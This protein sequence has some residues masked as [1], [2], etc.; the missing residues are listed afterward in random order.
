[1]GVALSDGRATHHRRKPCNEAVVLPIFQASR[2]HLPLPPGHLTPRPR[3]DALLS[4]GVAQD[5]GLVLVTAPPGYGKST[6]VSMWLAAQLRASLVAPDPG[7]R[8]TPQPEVLRFAWLSLD[9]GDNDPRRL[10]RHL[11]IALEAVAP[12]A[13]ARL[14][15]RL[16]AGGHEL[17]D[18]LADL[19]AMIAELSAPLVLAIDDA[20]L[21][22]D[23]RA[24]ALLA[25]LVE[26]APPPLRLVLCA[27]A[28]LP[29]PMVTL[30]ASGRLSELGVAELS[31]SADEAADLLG[32][33]MGLS[34]SRG[35]V[36]LLAERSGGWAADL[37]LVGLALQGHPQ[38]AELLA[39]LARESAG[40]PTLA[41]S[42]AA[43][44]GGEGL[45]A[46]HKRASLWHEQAGLLDEAVHY[47]FASGDPHF[48]AALLERQGIALL[49]R[50]EHSALRA[51]CRA[52]PETIYTTRPRLCLI[53]AWSLVLDL[54]GDGRE[55]AERR[56]TQ[57]ERGLAT[58]D[59]AT[60]AWLTGHRAN[61]RGHLLLYAP[62]PDFEALIVY[63]RQA[64]AALPEDDAA[65]RSVSAL[66][67]AYGNM[68]LSDAEGALN[69]LEVA[70]RLALKGR[71]YYGAIS[72]VFDRVR[73]AHQRGRLHEAAELCRLWKEALPSLVQDAGPVFPAGGCLDL[74]LGCVLL[75]RDD[76]AGA[77]ACLGRGLELTGGS[78][79]FAVAGFPA[80]AR[81]C[82]ARGDREGAEAALSRLQQVWPAT[83]FYVEGLLALLRLRAAPADP[84]VRAAARAWA[85]ANVPRVGPDKL[86]PGFGK[87]LADEP[88][89]GAALAWAHVQILL[90]RPREA[91]A[92]LEPLAIASLRGGLSHRLIELSVAQALALEVLG[93]RE[94]AFDALGR[95]LALAEGE[96]YVRVFAQE[97]ALAPLLAE[98]ST[99]KRAAHLAR[100]EASPEVADEAGVRGVGAL[101]APLSS[102]EIEVLRLLAGR[103]TNEQ[104][105]AR[106]VVSS[107][108]V[109]THLRHIYAKLGVSSRHEAIVR[110]IELRVLP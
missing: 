103:A 101:A 90:G 59:E 25:A 106:L 28:A 74:A 93:D 98:H 44:L 77:A 18:I 39:G 64:L 84:T 65:I 47:A 92:C 71:N 34:L 35:E 104:I 63:S 17:P 52:F 9:I 60:R 43:E 89:Y 91:L 79:Q 15:P 13:G 19:L 75:E 108:T 81:V 27:A 56:L 49:E 6:L 70:Q 68:G 42:L 94:R 38:P 8:A 109:K 48:A 95:A 10:L 14:L 97:P 5:A 2:F 12:A 31:F 72:C 3:L 99:T 20:Y 4:A 53:H 100:S 85:M 69:A 45:L 96:G 67:I 55:L 51:W 32:Q 7:P 83:Q 41:R 22:R 26:G 57:I 110:A 30:R 62:E 66:R 88:R 11:I 23:A 73:I 58:A 36:A 1:M 87:T 21:L 78:V 76:L 105:A 80:L 86:P 33:G 102:R 16:A 54:R 24:T 50:D 107:N 82:E 37:L 46:L 61:L 29:L 40:P